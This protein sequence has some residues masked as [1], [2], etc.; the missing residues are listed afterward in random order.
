MRR[1]GPR[2]D[3]VGAWLWTR[4]TRKMALLLGS[5]LSEPRLEAAQASN[6]VKPRASEP[7]QSLF[8]AE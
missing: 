4:G 6:C 2:F 3:A 5:R 7:G 1:R 8:A